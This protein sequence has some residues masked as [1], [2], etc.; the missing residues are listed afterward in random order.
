[1]K[2]IVSVL[3]VAL[4]VL[5]A[6]NS[7]AEEKNAPKNDQEFLIRAAE[8]GNAEIKFSELA[9]TRA[10][11]DQVKDFARQMVRE[12]KQMSDQL[13]S[14][15]K[16]LKTAVLAGLDKDANAAYQ[17][18]S[19]LRGDEFDRAYMQQMVEDHEKAVRLFEGEA[20]S[21][22]TSDLKT[23]AEKNL[24]TIRDHLK[25]ARSVLSTLKGK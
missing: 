15:A 22:G 18:L 20:K 5:V 13:S 11:N 10:N 19:K 7:W 8:A 1:M 16:E 14:Y 2:P 24:P 6:G 25:H 21:S 23:F 17:R 3:G 9:E 4:V 12:H